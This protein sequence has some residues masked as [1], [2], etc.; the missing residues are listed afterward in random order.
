M[1]F[2]FVFSQC[3][4]IIFNHLLSF[5][6]IGAGRHIIFRNI[7]RSL[8][9]GE[10]TENKRRRVNQQCE[11]NQGKKLFECKFTYL[12]NIYPYEIRF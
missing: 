9:P 12:F 11:I 8:L 10:Q 7:P 1:K 3:I 6:F 5:L 4:G 2:I